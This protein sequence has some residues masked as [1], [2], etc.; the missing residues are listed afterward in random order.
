MELQEASHSSASKAESEETA[1]LRRL[2]DEQRKQ[3]EEL[4]RS[5]EQRA[6][7]ME[8]RQK[9]FEESERQLKKR[10]EAL[11]QMEEKIKAVIPIE[12]QSQVVRDNDQSFLTSAA[13]EQPSS[14]WWGSRG[15][16]TTQADR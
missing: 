4:R 5:G 14:W 11:D 13:K 12:L 10:K 16:P 1:K 3:L 2:V 15:W 7:Q 9:A 6:K 8:E